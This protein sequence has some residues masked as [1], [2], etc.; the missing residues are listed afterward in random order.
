MPEEPIRGPSPE[1]MRL[2]RELSAAREH[3]AQQEVRLAEAEIAYRATN[4]GA[5]EGM[6][7][8]ELADRTQRRRLLR[9]QVA[10]EQVSSDEYRQQEHAG[11]ARQGPVRGLPAGDNEALTPLLIGHHI[12]GWERT[13]PVTGKQQV[14]LLQLTADGKRERRHTTNTLAHR[15]ESVADV[16][17]LFATAH[18]DR[19]VEFAGAKLAAE[20]AAV[21][22]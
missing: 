9:W 21:C 8:I 22:R 5:A 2:R 13:H 20:L 19:L 3:A 12:C 7:E 6:R 14:G 1:V 11:G 10:A 15:C 16:V 4:D 17:A 18:P